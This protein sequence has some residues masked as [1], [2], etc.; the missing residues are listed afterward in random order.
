[1][2]IYIWIYVDP[3]STQWHNGG[4]VMI[5]ASNLDDAREQW[6]AY[7]RDEGLG[8]SGAVS[9]MPDRMYRL[10]PLSSYVKEVLVFEDAGCC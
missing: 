7:S 2:Y 9:G 10:D 4:G 3:V 6:K 1:M 5:A 8:S